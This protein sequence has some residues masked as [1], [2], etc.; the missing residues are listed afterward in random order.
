MKFSL[1]KKQIKK[2]VEMKIEFKQTA[3]GGHILF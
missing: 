2:D 1:D 3:G